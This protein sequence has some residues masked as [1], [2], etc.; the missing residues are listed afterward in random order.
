MKHNLTQVRRRKKLFA[1]L[2]SKNKPVKKIKH[3]RKGDYVKI[4]AG[5]F[6]GQHGVITQILNHKN[7]V[8]IDNINVR[9][10]KIFVRNENDTL[11]K[12]YIS[13]PMGIHSSNVMIFDQENNIVKR[14]GFKIEDN[15]KIRYFKK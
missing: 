11:V 15:K 10:A 4:I 8:V 9:L 5:S 14:S 7:L 3:I 12:K 2:K 6:R 13:K 1:S